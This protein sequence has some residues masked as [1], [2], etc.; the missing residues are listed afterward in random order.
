MTTTNGLEFVR[1]STGSQ[2]ESTQVTTLDSYAAENQIR[3]AADARMILHGYSASHGAQEPALREAIEGIRQGR[4]KVILVTDSSRLDRREDLDAQAEILLSIRQAGGDVISVT[5]PQFGKTDFAGRM[6]TLV[7][8]YG[9]AE[10]SR[11]VKEQTF[12]GVKAIIANKALYGALPPFWQATGERFH[13]K[14]SC[15]DPDKVRAIYTAIRNGHSLSSVA[16]D[17]D[18][19][20]AS[21]K[22][23]IKTRANTT[24]VFE[25]HYT[26][27]GQT[28]TWKHTTEGTPPVDAELWNAAKRVMNAR[29]KAMDNRGGRPVNQ[30]MSW[31]SG[32]LA[33][34]KCGGRLYSQRGK[35]LR[36]GGKLKN[37]TACGIPAI[38]QASVQE[39]IETI[40]SSDNVMVYRYQRVSGNQG[41][42]DELQAELDRLN[43]MP[44]TSIPRDQ[45]SAHLDRITN[46]EDEIASFELV[47]DT[48][49]MSPTGET[50]ADLWQTG[51]KREIM[52]AVMGHIKFSVNLEGHVWIEGMYPGRQLIELDDETCIKVAHVA[53]QRTRLAQYA[54]T[55]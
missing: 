45:R 40:V 33:C 2:D 11:N 24:G 8:Q 53:R 19:Y 50:L 52:K 46:A 12:R 7:A 16:H 21:I 22:T 48:H 1:V 3:I 49:K 43:A 18:S 15:T 27:A 25:C 47:P 37:R 10:K 39:Q 41:E 32:L 23:L 42:F 38:D 51:D 55:A 54:E 30:A 28:Y 5:E 36:C 13:K 6:V 31:I 20:P 34:P 29:S 26:Y 9:N 44:I 4:W 17:Y 35:N 14:A